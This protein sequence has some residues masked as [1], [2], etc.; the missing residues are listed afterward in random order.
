MADPTSLKELATQQHAQLQTQKTATQAVVDAAHADFVSTQQ[1][2]Q[3]LLTEIADLEKEI[4]E[5]RQALGN[6]LMPSDGDSAVDDLRQLIIDFRRKRSTLLTSDDALDDAKT[7]VEF[8]Q[9]DLVDIESRLHAAATELKAATNRDDLHQSWQ[10]QLGIEPM[11]AIRAD[12]TNVLALTAPAGEDDEEKLNNIATYAAAKARVE[13]D[14]PESLRLRATARGERMEKQLDSIRA[15]SSSADTLVAIHLKNTNGPAANVEKLNAE[16]LAAES[17]LRSYVTHALEHLA[18]AS[19]LANQVNSSIE[20][21]VAETE[22]IDG[23]SDPDLVTDGEAAI[24][25][26][27]DRDEKQQAVADAEAALNNKIVELKA[28][29]IDVDISANAEVTTLQGELDTAQGEL[30]TAE[31]ALTQGVKNSLDKWEAAVPDPVWK[32]L[33]RFNTATQTLNELKDTDPADL[34]DA[35]ND[36]EAAL[37]AGLTAADKNSRTFDFLTDNKDSGILRLRRAEQTHQ[38]RV[39]GAVRGD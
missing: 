33:V 1:S 24:A 26:E 29:D 15:T 16:F 21:T 37:I 31:A 17:R 10:T 22:E 2:H 8:R 11:S 12:A 14:I 23:T 38:V 36:A 20:L 35:M 13:Q 3:T 27:K 34:T 32:N 39:L 4:E 25:V 28:A 9:A 19:S 30:V 18:G 6:A 7:V 5:T